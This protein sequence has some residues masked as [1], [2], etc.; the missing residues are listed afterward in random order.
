M[1]ITRRH[2]LRTTAGGSTS[3]LLQPMLQRFRLEAA[4]I[5]RTK[6]PHRFVFVMKSSG[7]I[8]ERLEPPTLKDAIG[9]RSLTVNEPLVNHELPA[10]LKPLEPFKDQVA[11]IQGLSGKMCRPGHSSW[12]GAMG[13]YKTGGEHNSGVLLRA[14]ADAELARLF[15]SPFQHVGLA[16]RGKVMSKE[17]EG[18]LYPGITAVGP[19]RELPFQASPDVAYQQLFGSALSADEKSQLQYDLKSNLL[20]FMVRDIGKLNQALPSSEREKMGHY[21]NAFEELQLRRQRLASMSDKIRDSAPEFSDRFS[22]KQNTIRQQAHVDL[23]AAALISGITNVVT[24]RLDNISTSYA[25]LGLSEKTVH[26]IGHQEPCNGKS[27]E[28]ARDIIRLHHMKLLADLAAQLKAVPEGDGNLLDNTSIIYLSDSG[29]EH[30][31]NLNEWPYVVIGGN[32]GRLNIAGR[33]LQFPSYGNDGH[34]TIGNW[35]TTWLNA[36]GNPI[37]HYGNLDLAMQ[38]NGMPQTGSLSELMT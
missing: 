36:F 16:L 11:I 5:E 21:L 35:W 24:L 10:T 4:G 32:G 8:P 13:V 18:T 37:E 30:H 3:L 17:I 7:I 38:K 15:P 23:S 6:M 1:T 12:F 31:G 28:E 27:P 20:D 22:A 14:T 34:R 9:D 25:Q 19:G 29:N 2:F 33:Y 26:G